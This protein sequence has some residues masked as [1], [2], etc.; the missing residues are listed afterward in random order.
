[1]QQELEQ[2]CKEM[3]ELYDNHPFAPLASF[4]AITEALQMVHHSHHWQTHGPEFYADHLLFE[5]LYTAILE[6]IDTVGEK[7]IG[8]SKE[9]KLT[10]YFARMKAMDKFLHMVTT[11]E[12]YIN[13]SFKA[14]QIYLAAGEH[15]MKTLK[16]AGLLSPGLEQMIGNILDKHESHVYL[17]MQRVK[18]AS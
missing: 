11:Q 1:M 5:R 3:M 4:L 17:L 16:E 14:E 18:P 15:M 7:L 10:N 2:C 13:V 12:P 9:S 6:E 8:V